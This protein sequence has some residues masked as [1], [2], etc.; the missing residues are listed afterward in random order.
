MAEFVSFLGGFAKGMSGYIDQKLLEEQQEKLLKK[1]FLEEEKK[2]RAELEA[3]SAKNHDTAVGLQEAYSLTQSQT[4]TIYF[5]LQSGIMKPEDVYG[6]SQQFALENSKKAATG[7][8]TTQ[9]QKATVTGPLVQEKLQEDATSDVNVQT[10][11][12]LNEAQSPAS[13]ATNTGLTRSYSSAPTLTQEL[14]SAGF[15]DKLSYLISPDITDPTQV[16]RMGKTAQVDDTNTELFRFANNLRN[17]GELNFPEDPERQE[18]LFKAIELNQT[19]G[20]LLRDYGSGEDADFAGAARGAAQT[21][22]EDPLVRSKWINHVVQREYNGFV[23]EGDSDNVARTKALISVTAGPEYASAWDGTGKGLNSLLG[24]LQ[25][26]EGQDEGDFLGASAYTRLSS[27]LTE[28]RQLGQLP[29]IE[30]LD[31]E[32]ENQSPLTRSG[33]ARQEAKA[34][35]STGDRIAGEAGKFAVAPTVALSPE[36]ASRTRGLGTSTSAPPPT[37]IPDSPSKVGYRTLTGTGMPYAEAGLARMPQ[38]VSSITS[39][40]LSTFDKMDVATIKAAITNKETLAKL[41]EKQGN[42][43]GQQQAEMDAAALK[44]LVSERKPDPNAFLTTSFIGMDPKE[45]VGIMFQ[46]EEY[47]DSPDTPEKERESATRRLEKIEQYRSYVT[48]GEF[49]FDDFVKDPVLYA[50]VLKWND[51]VLYE[52]M[53]PV[54]EK[55]AK[56]NLLRGVDFSQYNGMEDIPTLD[57]YLQ[58]A[59]EQLDELPEDDVEGRKKADFN[60][61]LIKATAKGIIDA[62]PKQF[63]QETLISEGILKYKRLQD[64]EEVFR[65]ATAPNSTDSPEIIAAKKQDLIS[66]EKDFK[67]HQGILEERRHLIELVDPTANTSGLKRYSTNL[68]DLVLAEKRYADAVISGDPER[69]AQA[70]E[71]LKTYHLI[72][73][74]RAE[75]VRQDARNRAQAEERVKLEMSGGRQAV[76]LDGEVRRYTEEEIAEQG[77]VG[78]PLD[79]NFYDLVTQNTARDQKGLL[80]AQSTQNSVLTAAGVAGELAEIVENDPAVLTDVA[81]VVKFMKGLETEFSTGAEFLNEGYIL[82]KAQQSGI[83]IV[84]DKQKLRAGD[85]AAARSLFK[86]KLIQLGFS[87]GSAEGTTG[88]A[89]SN[90]DYAN[91]MNMISAGGTRNKRTF[92]M[93]LNSYLQSKIAS[94]NTTVNNTRNS[95]GLSSLALSAV[96]PKARENFLKRYTPPTFE[97]Y[98]E[99]NPN[100][101]RVK[102]YQ[103]FND[104][105]E[106]QLGQGP[107]GASRGLGAPPIEGQ[108]DVNTYI[109]ALERAIQE[110]KFSGSDDPIARRDIAQ[111]L[112]KQFRYTAEQLKKYPQAKDRIE[113]LLFMELNMY[114]ALPETTVRNLLDSYLANPANNQ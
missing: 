108:A 75:Q 90:Q 12:L 26:M 53:K 62:N 9:D 18:R 99:K 67:A 24:T 89:M 25:Q 2:R 33:K 13:E 92:L 29:T 72:H 31:S 50:E 37:I 57:L 77:L 56:K 36:E 86:S 79:V 54:F 16:F 1:Q 109:P 107:L 27:A 8:P 112:D 97:E 102:N 7:V 14:G 110:A 64:A 58:V 106:R 100:D 83:D 51:P 66:A 69:I 84:P 87:S 44:A 70:D 93:N 63:T 49:S 74:K 22:L 96:A 30:Q 19:T 34:F 94:A 6:L 10:E 23:E 48:S 15:S 65:Q 81:D 42:L 11:R 88:N 95:S 85:L 80:L 28:G 60:I 52:Q 43:E 111:T 105:V 5:N 98:L 114:G 39:L 91:L 20:G 3:T 45:L 4:N 73:E 46:L 101:P 41:Y 76:G 61:N 47:I 32:I 59:K 104:I 55:Q 17:N 40:D 38:L 35:A 82:G 103:K 68:T 78:L 71:D 21:L 113:A